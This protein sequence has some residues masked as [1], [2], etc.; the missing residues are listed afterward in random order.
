MA[1]R[2]N[3]IWFYLLWS[4][5]N[6]RKCKDRFAFTIMRETASTLTE[7]QSRFVDKL[8]YF[9]VFYPQNVTAVLKR[10]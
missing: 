6:G 5:V 1:P 9:H 3:S 2:N 8:L 4:P 10:P 7:P